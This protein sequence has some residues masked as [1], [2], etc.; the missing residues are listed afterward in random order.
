MT[1]SPPIVSHAMILAAGL[2]TRL[3]RSADAPPKALTLLGGRTLL[4]HALDRLEDAGV[5]HVVVNV[6]HKADEVEAALAARYGAGSARYSVSDERAALLETG[7]GVQKALPLLPA[8][9]F[10]VLNCDAWWPPGAGGLE[11]LRARFDGARMAACLL[12]AERARVSGVAQDDF[13]W[14]DKER[15][16]FDNAGGLVYAGAQLVQPSVFAHAPPVSSKTAHFSFT[17]VWRAL[18]PHALYGASLSAPWMHIGTPEGLA[19]AEQRLA[20]LRPRS[21]QRPRPQQ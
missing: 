5:R 19:E 15:L 13:A 16:R 8:A 3:R 12:V 9:P 17:E 18:A 2:G 11:A 4:N 21:R 20:A 10:F 6:H 7:G 1:R 14:H